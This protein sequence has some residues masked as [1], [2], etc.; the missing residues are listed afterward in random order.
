ML[1]QDVRRLGLTRI[2]GTQLTGP[3]TVPK[4]QLAPDLA[5]LKAAEQREGVYPEAGVGVARARAARTLTRCRYPT[6]RC[7]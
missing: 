2:G 4:F 6:N 1:L 5:H 7:S 3:E